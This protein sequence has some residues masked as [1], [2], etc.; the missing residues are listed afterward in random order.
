MNK[1]APP[2]ESEWRGLYLEECNA[3]VLLVALHTVRIN[4]DALEVLVDFLTSEV[5]ELPALSL[6]CSFCLSDFCNGLLEGL[7]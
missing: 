6:W 1:K 3:I 4:S 5:E 7:T 2:L